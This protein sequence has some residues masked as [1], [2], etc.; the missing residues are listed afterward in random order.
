MGNE[1]LHDF[2]IICSA[3]GEWLHPV[4]PLCVQACYS[5][6]SGRICQSAMV[7]LVNHSDFAKVAEGSPDRVWY[8]SLESPWTLWTF[9]HGLC[10]PGMLEQCPWTLYMYLFF[11][12]SYTIFRIWVYKLNSMD[13]VPWHFPVRLG[14]LEYFSRLS[15]DKVQTVYWVPGLLPW[16]P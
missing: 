9:V 2:K 15:M 1:K 3:R 13:F 5:R 4:Y 16:T 12:F 14:S 7:V 8:P 6:I 11:F 10:L